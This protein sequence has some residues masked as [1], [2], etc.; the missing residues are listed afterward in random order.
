MF[1]KCGTMPA[2]YSRDMTDVCEWHLAQ[3]TLVQISIS[4]ASVGHKR[5]AAQ[6]P[7]SCSEGPA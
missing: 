4:L 1:G 7:E 3:L 2:S 6:S 5:K